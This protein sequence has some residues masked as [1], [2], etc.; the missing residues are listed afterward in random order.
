MLSV[1]RDLDIASLPLP[2][3]TA[4]QLAE[5]HA[6]TSLKM[7]DCCALLAAEDAEASVASFDDRLARTARAR[8]L[9]VLPTFR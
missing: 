9:P 8:H 3:D 7:P 1:L 5:L 2:A 6:N 4:V